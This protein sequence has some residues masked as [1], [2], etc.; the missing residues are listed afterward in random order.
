MEAPL[1][2]EAEA[3]GTYA[4]YIDSVRGLEA[5]YRGDYTKSRALFSELKAK[6]VP[7]DLYG[8]LFES[9]LA[10]IDEAEAEQAK[11]KEE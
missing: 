2:T 8:P 3:N 1:L 7:G 11:E 6:N 5:F 9:Y 4:L 10:K